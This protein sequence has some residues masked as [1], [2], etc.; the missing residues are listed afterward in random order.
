MRFVGEQQE[1]AVGLGLWENSRRSLLGQVC[2]LLCSL[3][4]GLNT[5]YSMH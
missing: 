3:V 4:V 5:F 1:V 2:K